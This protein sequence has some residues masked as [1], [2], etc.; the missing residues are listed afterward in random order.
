MPTTKTSPK[1]RP[2]ATRDAFIAAAA[3]AALMSASYAA[4]G[5]GINPYPTAY[6]CLP[7]YADLWVEDMERVVGVI[8]GKIL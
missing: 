3:L 4:N 7:I 2:R 6:I 8:T 5:K 1:Q